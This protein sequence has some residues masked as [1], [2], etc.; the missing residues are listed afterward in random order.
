MF[1][2]TTLSSKFEARGAWKAACFRA[3]RSIIET[4]LQ[5]GGVVLWDFRA[6]SAS[7]P[8]RIPDHFAFQPRDAT[9]SAERR[10][11]CVVLVSRA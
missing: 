4:S 7:W 10:E 2:M 1:S 9:T 5:A 6:A 3:G 11:R 8:N